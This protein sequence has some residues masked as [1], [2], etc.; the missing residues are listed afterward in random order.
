MMKKQ[1]MEAKEWLEKE[2]GVEFIEID[3][4]PLKEACKSVYTNFPHLLDPEKVKFIDS[5]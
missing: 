4:T 2:Q 3:V 5:M 1:N